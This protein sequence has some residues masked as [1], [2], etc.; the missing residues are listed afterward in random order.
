[1]AGIPFKWFTNVTDRSSFVFNP[2]RQSHVKT[3][4]TNQLTQGILQALSLE[5]GEDYGRGYFSALNE[6]VLATY[7]KHHRKHIGSFKQLHAFVSDRNA[8]PEIGS[9]DDWEKT[10]HLAARRR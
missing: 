7:M 8:L 9:L 5:Y 4:T 3:M 2:L 6:S 1:M 10:R